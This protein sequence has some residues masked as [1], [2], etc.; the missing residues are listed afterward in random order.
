LYTIFYR[1]L[2]VGK[3]DEKEDLVFL[4]GEFA[5]GRDYPGQTGHSF[6]NPET[7]TF[8]CDS[9]AL[10]NHFV[11]DVAIA[12]WDDEHPV[13]GA[14]GDGTWLIKNSLGTGYGEGGYCWISYWDTDFLKGE[15]PAYVFIAAAG[16]GYAWPRRF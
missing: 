14:P 11:H 2:I 8:Y 6:Y 12:G 7:S 9:D 16:R 15:S 4:F 5:S 3:G 10:V 1:S 13:S